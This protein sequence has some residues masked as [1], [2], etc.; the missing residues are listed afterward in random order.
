MG[1]RPLCNAFSTWLA[2]ERRDLSPALKGLIESMLRGVSN[3]KGRGE[4]DRGRHRQ[5]ARLSKAGHPMPGPQ[6]GG[7]PRRDHAWGS[8]AQAQVRQLRR[9]EGSSGDGGSAS[10]A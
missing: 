9:A 6:N 3:D 4:K 10:P 7:T 5:P 2:N 8:W 1:Q